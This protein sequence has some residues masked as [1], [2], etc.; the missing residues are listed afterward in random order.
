MSLRS[1]IFFVN[2]QCFG[3]VLNLY[4]YPYNLDLAMNEER[5]EKSHRA[6]PKFSYQH[7]HDIKSKM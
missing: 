7:R 2:Q 5:T 3:L 4:D 6:V 1:R